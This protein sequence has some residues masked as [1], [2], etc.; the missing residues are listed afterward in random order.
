MSLYRCAPILAGR[1]ACGRVG[2]AAGEREPPA[3][4]TVPVDAVRDA[5]VADSAVADAPASDSAPGPSGDLVE[6]ALGASHTCARRASGSVLCWGANWAGQLGDGTTASRPLAGPVPGLDDAVQ[7]AAGEQ[8]TCA[9]R[10]TGVAVCWGANDIGMLG[11]G[12]TT[13]RLVPTPV[14]GLNDAVEIAT[15]PQAD[16]TCARRTTGQIACW[17][18]NGYG[19]LGTGGPAPSLFPIHLLPPL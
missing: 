7:I 15:A 4:G 2:C 8:H 9:V 17:G 5:S 12:T 1:A 18:S 10:A 11:D 13:T 19:E 14:S 3:D 6:L 16:H